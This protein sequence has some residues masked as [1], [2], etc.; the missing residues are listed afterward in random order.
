[1][2]LC[3]TMVKYFSKSKRSLICNKDQ[4]RYVNGAVS[5]KLLGEITGKKLKCKGLFTILFTVLKQ[6]QHSNTQKVLSNIK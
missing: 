2:L 3:V 5:S 6:P 4:G 1:M